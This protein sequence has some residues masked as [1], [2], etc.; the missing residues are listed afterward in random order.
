MCPPPG[1]STLKSPTSASLSNVP[2]VFWTA[3]QAFG[4]IEKT[5]PNACSAIQNLCLGS[6]TFLEMKTC[7]SRTLVARLLRL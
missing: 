1:T 6:M 2:T 3:E 4:S 7:S 5:L